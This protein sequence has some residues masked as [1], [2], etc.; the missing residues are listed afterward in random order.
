MLTII[1][2]KDKVEGDDNGMMVPAAASR[3]I[4]GMRND[5]GDDTEEGKDEYGVKD[6]RSQLKLKADHDS[7]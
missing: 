2:Q 6:V 3:N 7:R 4:G 1:G 5:D